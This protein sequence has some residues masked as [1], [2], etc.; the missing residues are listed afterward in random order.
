MRSL[1]CAQFKWRWQLLLVAC[2]ILRLQDMQW[3]CRKERA[4]SPS[5]RCEIAGGFAG[6]SQNVAAFG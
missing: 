3:L 5:Q 2:A 4:E 6:K 1:K